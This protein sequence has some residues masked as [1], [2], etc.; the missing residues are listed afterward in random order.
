MDGWKQKTEERAAPPWVVA[1]QQSWLLTTVPGGVL[2]SAQV[3]CS[4]ASAGKGGTGL[5][6]WFPE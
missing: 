2:S 3:L 6:L 1:H 4:L 5:R